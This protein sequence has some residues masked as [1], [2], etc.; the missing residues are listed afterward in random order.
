MPSG[1]RGCSSGTWIRPSGT[2]GMVSGTE[3]CIKRLFG[4]MR[5]IHRQMS[6]ESF[7]PWEKAFS[8]LVFG[9]M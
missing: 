7:G 1:T 3:R 9:S 2:K 6:F 5:N 8:I 4:G